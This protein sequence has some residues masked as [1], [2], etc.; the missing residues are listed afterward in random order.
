M[1]GLLQY[2]KEFLYKYTR[3][4]SKCHGYKHG[5]R[6]AKLTLKLI[7][8]DKVDTLLA[9]IVA[10]FHD[11]ADSKFNI[12][13][14][15]FN[16]LKYGDYFTCEKIWQIKNMVFY[17]SYTK[18]RLYRKYGIES[19]VLQR[20]P[21]LKYVR[22]ADRLESLGMRGLKRCITFTKFLNPFYT[23]FELLNRVIYL[24]NSRFLKLV[25]KKYIVTKTAIPK[26]LKRQKIMTNK[27]IYFLV[28]NCY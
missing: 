5:I 2:C 10:L 12:S 25:K 21:E 4:R 6:V 17:V 23:K 13:I 9:Y 22:D 14:C 19:N 28:F 15:V 8:D 27:L 16:K 18:E 24:N 26:A 11:I 3:N 20:Y 7:G 1:Q